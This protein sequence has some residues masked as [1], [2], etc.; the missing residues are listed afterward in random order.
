MNKGD[1]EIPKE[2]KLFIIPDAGSNDVKELNDLVRKGIDCICLDHHEV[3]ENNEECLA[4]IVNNQESEKYTCKDFSGVGVVYEFLRAL[5]E[6]YM[7]DMADDYLDLV[8]FGNISDVMSIKNFQTRYYI[9]R[10]LGNIKNK[11][12]KALDKAQEFSTNGEINIHNISWYWT[13]I[14]NAM[15]RVGDKEDRDLMFRAF[16]ET[17]EV[18]PYKKRGSDSIVDEDIYTRAARLCKNIKSRQDKMRDALCE[19]LKEDVNPEDKIIMVAASDD[20]D[21]GII[22]LAAM[23]LADWSGKPCI[24]LREKT[25]GV[26]NG[27][28]R[29]CKNSPVKD[30]KELVNSTKLFNWGM[31]HSNAFGCEICEDNL[32]DARDALNEAL[33]NIEYDDTIYCDFILNVYDVDYNFIKTID[34]TKWIYGTGIEEPIVAIENIEITP[35][36]CAVIG[37]N[38]DTVTFIYNGIKYCKFKCNENDELLSFANGYLGDEISL[39]VVGKCSINTYK[40]IST[41]Q[42]TI[43]NYEV[44]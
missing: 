7:Y 12:L 38:K 20:A 42:V 41:L 39:N 17:D 44:V 28:C 14:C 25:K 19:K 2:T 35:Y 24:V 22:G 11:F 26:F 4:I 3:E 1:F 10:G 40:D 32:V 16:I 18:F 15:I 21:P 9:E 31:G 23:R 8:A 5:D 33:E 13:P 37:A 6:F 36:D 29:N 43:D 30:L 27:S 34:D